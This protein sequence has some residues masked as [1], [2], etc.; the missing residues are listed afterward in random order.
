MVTVPE[1]VAYL[2]EALPA[3]AVGDGRGRL[4]AAEHL[5]GLDRLL[6]ARHAEVRNRSE[7]FNLSQFGGRISARDTEIWKIIMISRNLPCS[8]SGSKQ[9]KEG[10]LRTKQNAKQNMRKWNKKGE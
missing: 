5:H 6:L 4:L 3:L 9:E 8:L 2:D 7:C 1:V 10:Q